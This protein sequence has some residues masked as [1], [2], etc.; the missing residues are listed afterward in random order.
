MDTVGGL[1]V[2]FGEKSCLAVGMNGLNLV[3]R[4]GSRAFT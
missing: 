2:D 1:K 3:T 4:F